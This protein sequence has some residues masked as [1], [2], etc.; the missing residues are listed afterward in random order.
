MVAT[1]V[2]CS[3]LFRA[4]PLDELGE[5]VPELRL[6]RVLAP[7]ITIK[8]WN[9]RGV[10]RFYLARAACARDFWP[11]HAWRSHKTM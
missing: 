7:P 9:L 8:A 10:H 3:A 1:P 4:N 6:Q 5:P 2:C 11:F